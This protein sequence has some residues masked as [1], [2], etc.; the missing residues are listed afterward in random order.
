MDARQFVQGGLSEGLLDWIEAQSTGRQ[1]EDLAA[2]IA[3]SRRGLL[4]AMGCGSVEEW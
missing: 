4:V 3:K 1:I 2:K